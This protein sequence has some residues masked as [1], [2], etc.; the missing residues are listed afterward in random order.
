M[1]ACVRFEGKNTYVQY[2]IIQRL[3]V[4][5]FSIVQVSVT[6]TQTKEVTTL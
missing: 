5:Y 4:I 3:E 6:Q 1:N 2:S